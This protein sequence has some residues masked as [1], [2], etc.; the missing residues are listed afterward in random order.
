VRKVVD[1]DID[2]IGVPS[3]L[4]RDEELG[5]AAVNCRREAFLPQDDRTS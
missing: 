3:Q 4:K 1:I 2:M 5:M